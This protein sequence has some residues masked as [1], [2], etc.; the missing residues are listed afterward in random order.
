[1][2]TSDS[3]Q[4]RRQHL[5]RTASGLF[6]PTRRPVTDGVLDALGYPL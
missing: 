6:L 4:D 2:L 5:N 1:M 3:H